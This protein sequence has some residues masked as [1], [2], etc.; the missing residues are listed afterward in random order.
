MQ[1]DL[2]YPESVESQGIS[3]I[4]FLLTDPSIGSMLPAPEVGRPAAM[5][6]NRPQ[7]DALSCASQYAQVMLLPVFAVYRI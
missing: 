6:T 7:L 3:L 5:L 4:F 1:M 2:F